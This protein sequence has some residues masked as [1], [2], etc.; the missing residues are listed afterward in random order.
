[1]TTRGES[2]PAHVVIVGA[3]AVGLTYGLA[4]QKA[5]LR[6]SVY[7]REKYAEEPAYR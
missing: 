3:G 4:L 1:M 2:V 6:V 7:V 5:G